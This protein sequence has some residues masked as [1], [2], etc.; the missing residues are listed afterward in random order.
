MNTNWFVYLM[1][2]FLIVMSLGLIG[3]KTYSYKSVDWE[4][5]YDQID[6]VEFEKDLS[7]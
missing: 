5:E 4:G 2:L 7:P 3:C 6:D 1:V